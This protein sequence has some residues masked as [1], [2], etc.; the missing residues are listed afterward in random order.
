L[1][2]SP[3]WYL[4]PLLLA[5]VGTAH[6]NRVSISVA[7]A[8]AI[9]SNYGIDPTQMG[10]IYSAYL[11]FYTLA[12]APGGWLIDRFGAKRALLVVCIGSA[13]FVTLTAG[14][15]FLWTG[16]V[17]WIALLIV[18]SLMGVTNVP[19]HPGAAHMVGDWI[20]PENRNVVNGLVT[21]AACVGMSATYL[22]FGWMLDQLG[23]VVASFAA[24]G[25]TLLLSL[26]WGICAA[27]RRV[28]RVS[29]SNDP[30]L[31]APS[32]WHLLRNRSLL[33]LTLSYATVG[34]FQYLFFYWAQYYFEHVRGVSKEDSRLYTSILTLAMGLGMIAGGWFTD[35]ARTQI[36]HRRS[37]AIVPVSGLI[38]AALALVPGLI[39]Q[40]PWLTVV[41][42]AV[43]MTAA[44][45]S[46]GAFWT[47]AIEIGGRRG[48][49]AAGIMNTGGNA[50]GLIAPVLT[51]F[52]SAWL[53]WQAGL[54]LA[55]VVCLF[56]A[57]CWIW[58]EPQEKLD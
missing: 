49:L 36:R 44:G 57:F 19:T 16:N 4:V 43:A 46:E 1:N 25:G 18:R 6:F 20:R 24:G 9:I 48:G 34:Y 12:M 30:S 2:S 55:G 33:F 38:I 32:A 47:L 13:V 56:G 26:V 53:G 54:G 29:L 39:V 28:P 41:C 51:P 42:F 8:D 17:L 31:A 3:R 21:F 10:F 11:L 37:M 50:G 23:W 45:T 27:D 5:V 14:A 7:G 35:W 52:I 40:A 15:G 22:L 58:I